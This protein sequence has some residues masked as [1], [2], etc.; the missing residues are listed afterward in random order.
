LLA[1]F[2]DYGEEAEKFAEQVILASVRGFSKGEGDTVFGV[3]A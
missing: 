1:F 2:N 3:L